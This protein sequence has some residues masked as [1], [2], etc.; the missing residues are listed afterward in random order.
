MKISLDF[1]NC[2]KTKEMEIEKSEMKKR[3]KKKGLV[4][5]SQ[6]VFLGAAVI[7]ILTSPVG[8]Y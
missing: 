3:K 1:L 4:G 2:L 8:L 6:I 5:K 7:F